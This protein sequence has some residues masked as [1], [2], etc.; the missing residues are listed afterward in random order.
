M[1]FQ[2]DTG[3]HVSTEEEYQ[4]SK[5][6]T[7]EEALAEDINQGCPGMYLTLKAKISNQ[8]KQTKNKKQPEGQA[9]S[10]T[11]GMKRPRRSPQSQ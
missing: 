11:S 7:R 5:V 3:H 6:Y 2:L 9:Q 4:E 10:P 1:R 8:T